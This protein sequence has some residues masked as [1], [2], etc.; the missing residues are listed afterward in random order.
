MLFKAALTS[1]RGVSKPFL[2][3]VNKVPEDAKAVK[4]SSTVAVGFFSLITAQAPATCG[5]AME[6]PLYSSNKSPGTEE[7][8][9]TPGARRFRKL[10]E[11]E[12]QATLSGQG[13]ML[14]HS[15]S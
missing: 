15:G 13:L 10:A 5:A 8:I 2:V 12:K 1:M 4:T 3:S 14:V 6:V 7:S 11:F 9:Q